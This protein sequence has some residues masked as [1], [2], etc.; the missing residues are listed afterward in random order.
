MSLELKARQFKATMN[1]NNQ[2]T[3]DSEIRKDYGVTSDKEY[4]FEYV[5]EVEHNII[6]PKKVKEESKEKVD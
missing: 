3:V 4:I 2:I 6:K 5:G 1:S